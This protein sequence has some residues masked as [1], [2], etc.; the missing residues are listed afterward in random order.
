MFVQLMFSHFITCY[1]T[2]GILMVDWWIPGE[3][4]IGVK[5][6]SVPF[7]WPG[8]LNEAG[9]TYIGLLMRARSCS[10]AQ[11]VDRAGDIDQYSYILKHGL[12]IAKGCNT[13]FNEL[14]D[15]KTA[16]YTCTY[17]IGQAINPILLLG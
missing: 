4:P 1:K 15:F 10:S 9:S 2:F 11:Q 5:K 12:G 17:T 14:C 6:P 16:N 7:I 3:G 13:F 8:I